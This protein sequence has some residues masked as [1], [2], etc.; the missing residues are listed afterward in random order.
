MAQFANDWIDYNQRYFKIPIAQDGLYQIS[1]SQLASA[2]IPI[3]SIAP[4]RFQIFR[5]GQELAIKVDKSASNVV[6]A[7]SFYGMKNDGTGDTELYRTPEGQPHTLY[8]L[9]TDTAAYFLTWKLTGSGKRMANKTLLTPDA[10]EEYHLAELLKLP[11]SSYSDGDK[12]GSKNELASGMFDQGEGWF[13]PRNTK[14]GITNF[15]FALT[16]T[17]QDVSVKPR[18]EILMVGNNNL[19][20]RTEIL[21]GPATTSL[22]SLTTVEGYSNF[23]TKLISEGIEWSDLSGTGQCIVQVKVLGFPDV[24]D[25]QAVGYVKL[26][27][28]RV[29]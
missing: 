4:E 28:P 1:A 21:V 11:V 6:T 14:G 12:Y 10:A 20:H 24:A 17:R 8:N 26:F 15:T 9:Y 23:E 22:R 27:Y 13:G 3:T 2:G 19:S 5:R 16:N 7:I 29:I 18:V 25:A